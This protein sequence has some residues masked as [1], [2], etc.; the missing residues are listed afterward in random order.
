MT[1]RRR[2]IYRRL[3]RSQR[4]AIVHDVIECVWQNR[5][6]DSGWDAYPQELKPAAWASLEPIRS[7]TEEIA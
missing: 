3:T 2:P 1:D 5:L 4:R 7:L 6:Y